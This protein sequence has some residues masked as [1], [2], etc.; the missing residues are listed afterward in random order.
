MDCENCRRLT[1]VGLHDTGPRTGGVPSPSCWLV[2]GGLRSR[3][4]SVCVELIWV[5]GSSS[6]PLHLDVAVA[7]SCLSKSVPEIHEPVAVK[8]PTTTGGLRARA[9]PVVTILGRA[10]EDRLARLVVGVQALLSVILQ[11]GW[12]RYHGSRTPSNDDSPAVIPPSA[13]D[14]PTIMKRYHRR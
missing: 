14:K 2:T 11:G 8:Q 12:G 1:V 13:L 3:V 10:Y 6:S 9:V 4:V 5:A 7:Y